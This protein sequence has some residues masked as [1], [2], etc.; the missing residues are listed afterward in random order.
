MPEPSLI[1]T[2]AQFQ[3]HLRLPIGASSPLT[4][5]EEDQLLKLEVAQDQVFAYLARP[6]DADWTAR[7]QHWLDGEV[8][9]PAEVVPARVKGAILVQAAALWAF[10]G[11][12][13]EG[14][15]LDTPGELVPAAKSLLYQLR[16]PMAR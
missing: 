5:D 12:D 11:D 4:P 16:D 3:S 14:P 13:A 10:R 9:S 7:L 15:K 8:A 2:L 6:D 1:V